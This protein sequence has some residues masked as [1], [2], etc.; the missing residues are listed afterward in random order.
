MVYLHEHG[1]AGGDELNLIIAGANYGWPV[2]TYGKDYSGAYVT[3]LTAYPGMQQPIVDWTPSIAVSGLT[4]YR[5]QHFTQWQ[6]HALVGALV[7]Q[8]VRAV[9]LQNPSQ[10]VLLTELDQRIRDIREGPDGALY[11]L[12]DS[13][14]GRLLRIT[15]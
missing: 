11:I 3:P 15:P 12:T 8:S 6:G 9:S 4:I 1:P 14:D 13:A 5:G 2:I 10:Q 7:E